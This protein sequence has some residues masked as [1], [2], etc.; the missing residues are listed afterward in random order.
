MRTRDDSCRKSCVIRFL[1]CL[2]KPAYAFICCKILCKARKGVGRSVF[3]YFA[4]KARS[5]CD[6]VSRKADETDDIS[7]LEYSA[8]FDTVCDLRKVHVRE[9]LA[10]RIGGA[11]IDAGA[12]AVTRAGNDS[13]RRRRDRRPERSH[14]IE[15]FVSAPSASW[16]TEV[17]RQFFD[18]D[19][20]N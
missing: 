7:T 20:D 9:R 1:D 6:R 5:A 12:S 10:A 15:A 13:V 2:R 18:R 3:S 11:D 8:G 19:T 14:D 16:I 17:S 4:V